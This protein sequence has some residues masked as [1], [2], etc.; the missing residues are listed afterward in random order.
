MSETFVDLLYRGLPL[1]R[2]IKLT[3]VRPR[4][5]YLEHPTPM[6]V[7]TTIAISTDDGIVLD[8][9][10]TGVHE[11]IGGSENAPGMVVQ[12]ALAG[13]QIEGW[14]KTRVTLPEEPAKPVVVD[15][16]KPK[17]T[18]R[19]RTHT[20]PEPVPTDAPTV[21][22]ASAPIAVEAAPQDTAPDVTLRTAALPPEAGADHRR[23]KIMPALDQEL[24]EQ[25]ARN[26]EEIERLTRRTGEHEVVDD[27]LRT[28]VMDAVDPAALGLD[29]SG[30]MPAATDDD[31][32]D[33]DE[34]TPAGPTTG[35]D[36]KKPTKPRRR[37]KRR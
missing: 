11:Q 17:V 22:T 18:V 13:E 19:P 5:G 10:V 30:S 33:D 35:G 27:G 29:M 3:Q 25:L 9:V 28:T 2:R 24:L 14:W 36:D 1:G 32:G 23:T 7:G 6:P 34:S 26:P 4:S 31:N 21:P 37:K 20:V 8:A 15:P 16:P 12:P